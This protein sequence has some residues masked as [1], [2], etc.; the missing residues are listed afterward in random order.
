MGVLRVLTAV[1]CLAAAIAL[2]FLMVGTPARP[3][4]SAA[5]FARRPQSSQPHKASSRVTVPPAI[6]RGGRGRQALPMAAGVISP[7][8]ANR[9]ANPT[10]AAVVGSVGLEAPSSPSPTA[11]G[12]PVSRITLV[13]RCELDEAAVSVTLEL[14]ACIDNAPPNTAVEIPRGIYHFDRQVV[15]S[16]PITLRTEGSAA[17]RVTCQSGP[18]SCAR[19]VAAEGLFDDHGLL[20]VLKTSNVTLEHIVIDGNRLARLSAPAGAACRAGRNMMGVN[21]TVAGC[22]KCALRDFVSM[23]ALCG[24]GML[25]TGAQATIERSDFR[26]NGQPG[27]P[28]LWA[29]G[30]TALYAP[31]S[32]IVNNRFIDNSDVALILGYGARTRVEDNDIIQRERDLFA[33]IM[34]DNFTSDDLSEAGDFRGALVTDNI[35]DCRP[36]FCVFGIQLGPRPWFPGVN[37]VGGTISENQIHGAKVGINVDGAGTAE[38]PVK[39][40]S[41]RVTD[42]P[43]GVF[44]NCASIAT[45]WMNIAP[46]SVVDRSDEAAPTGSHL[47]DGCQLFSAIV[48]SA[49][50]GH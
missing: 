44:A 18:D 31:D 28:G 29:D 26:G 38:A 3:L 42:V 43:R 27:T 49:A 34:L 17:G 7:S 41:N 10:P 36:Q 40:F 32:L 37:I 4:N 45:D 47:S 19:L 48:P 6:G 35:V 16:K 22:V 46:T 5:V 20:L 2:V 15:I 13:V 25:W 11:E 39:I 1:V 50:T 23:N 30:L 14:Q 33:G 21:A 24:S 9:D 12:E 8:Q